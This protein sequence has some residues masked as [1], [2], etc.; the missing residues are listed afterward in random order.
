MRM[1]NEGGRARRRR[2]GMG[3]GA[4]KVAI[5]SSPLLLAQE[6]ST[7][8]DAM[9]IARQVFRLRGHPTI[10][11]FPQ[12]HGRVVRSGIVGGRHPSR[13]RNRPRFIRVRRTHG[14]P[15]SPPAHAQEAPGNCPAELPDAPNIQTASVHVQLPNGSRTFFQTATQASAGSC[16]HLPRSY[17]ALPRN[18]NLSYQ[19]QI[20]CGRS[21][22]NSP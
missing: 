15:Y 14:V 7:I 19:E 18:P 2:R 1:G 8:A 17:L 10:P 12:R 20:P 13:R 22:R 3:R 4:P 6:A 9:S 21:S 11:A 16:K 5:T